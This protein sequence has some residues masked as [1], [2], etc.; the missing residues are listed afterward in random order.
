MI[1]NFVLQEGEGHVAIGLDLALGLQRVGLI[2]VSGII[3]CIAGRRLPF[4]LRSRRIVPWS[5]ENKRT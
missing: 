1:A 2:G 3:I 4:G 5:I